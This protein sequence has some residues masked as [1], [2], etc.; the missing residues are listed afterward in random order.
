M[1]CNGIDWDW[2]WWNWKGGKENWYV[3]QLGVPM[4]YIFEETN[5]LFSDGLFQIIYIRYPI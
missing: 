5:E 2:D 1:V 3:H 4:K